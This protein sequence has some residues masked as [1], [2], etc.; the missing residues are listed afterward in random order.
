[1]GRELYWKTY[2]SSSPDS[3]KRR[4][5]SARRRA[6]V[7]GSSDVEHVGEVRAL[8]RGGEVEELFDAEDEDKED[9]AVVVAA[10]IV[11]P[12][13]VYALDSRGLLS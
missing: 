5:M 11:K 9:A 7:P 13:G 8:L 1:M 3:S 4:L 2:L 6:S 10:G 12:G